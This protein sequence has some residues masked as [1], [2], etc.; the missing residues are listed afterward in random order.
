M[1]RLAFAVA[2]GVSALYPTVA[3]ACTRPVK[4]RENDTAQRFMQVRSGKSCSVGFTSLGPMQSVKVTK[5]PSHGK[6]ETNHFMVV[7]YTA[8]AGYVGPDSFTYA[9]VGRDGRNNPTVRTIEV[10]V[11]VMP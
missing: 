11:T 3:D 7:K 5:R 10:T 6:V 8:Q 2:I 1:L 9:R 4:M